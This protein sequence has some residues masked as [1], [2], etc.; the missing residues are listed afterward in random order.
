MNFATCAIAC[1]AIII[2][3]MRRT[4]NERAIKNCLER[5]PNAFSIQSQNRKS[6]R[7]SR[8]KK[9]KG[10]RKHRKGC[11]CKRSERTVASKTIASV[12]KPKS[13]AQA[14]ANAS[15]AVKIWRTELTGRFHLRRSMFH[16]EFKSPSLA[17]SAPLKNKL[18]NCQAVSFTYND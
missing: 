11:N 10:L 6:E 13:A 14:I 17:G 3:S 16:D 1:R 8:R 4:D 12:M 2:W 9:G 18:R 15:S 5:N 7:H